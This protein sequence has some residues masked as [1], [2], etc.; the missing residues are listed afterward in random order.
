MFNMINGR[1]RAPIHI[2]VHYFAKFY[3]KAQ[4]HLNN[5]KLYF[6]DDSPKFNEALNFYRE[7]KE[8]IFKPLPKIDIYWEKYNSNYH[9]ERWGAQGEYYAD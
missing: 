1:F 2:G 9:Y 3:E 5:W 6:C 8:E 4:H 7:V